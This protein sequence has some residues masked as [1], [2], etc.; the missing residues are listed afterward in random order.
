MAD[1]ILLPFPHFLRFEILISPKNW[2]KKNQTT[3]GEPGAVPP[4]YVGAASPPL[5]RHAEVSL[6]GPRRDGWVEAEQPCLGMAEQSEPGR[7]RGGNREP[8]QSDL[9]LCKR[10]GYPFPLPQRGKPWLLHLTPSSTSAHSLVTPGRSIAVPKLPQ[11]GHRGSNCS[12]DG[13][14]VCTISP[15]WA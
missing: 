4:W 8:P 10:R 6:T 5:G 1:E 12:Y 2:I 3:Q 7:W 11:L 14:S 9:P 13:T 15:W